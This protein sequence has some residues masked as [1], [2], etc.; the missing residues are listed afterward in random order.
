MSDP[1]TA[2]AAEQIFKVEEE[3][4]K[5]A[6]TQDESDYAA[7]RSQ[8]FQKTNE[9][10]K[11]QREE[12][13]RQLKQ[14]AA[15]TDLEKTRADLE[16]KY[17]NQ[18]LPR[19]QAAEKAR[20]EIEQKGQEVRAGKAPT[21]L[22]VNDQIVQWDQSSGTW[23]EV[24]PQALP[25]EGGPPTVKLTKEQSD[26]LQHLTKVRIALDQ[27]GRVRDA[28]KILAEGLKDELAGK[29]AVLRQC[30]AVGE[31]SRRPQRGIQ[32]PSRTSALD[33]RRRHRGAGN[34]DALL[35]PGAALRRRPGHHPQQSTAA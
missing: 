5:R 32:F 20:L 24:K 27:Y 1:A 22:T 11:F 4:R 10:E 23:K 6:E 16:E 21:H 9:F 7:A 29:T 19:V 28:D 18:G 12:A 30:G 3:F 26:E 15:R 31:I 34:G 8:H 25:S 33:Q 2:S 14:Q 13:D 35:Q 17:Y